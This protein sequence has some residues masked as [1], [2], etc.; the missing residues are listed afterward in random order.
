MKLLTKDTDYA[1]R[2]LLI[3]AQSKGEFVSV[4]EI[5]KKQNMPYHFLRR[6]LRELIKNKIV[7]AKE[8][9]RGGVKIGKDPASVKI[10][11]L[12]KI[13]QGDIRFLECRLRG[14]VC[15]NYSGCTLREKIQKIEDMA[16]K[17]F[18]KITLKALIG[19]SN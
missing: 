2:A 15:R 6:V 10:K 7:I 16:V 14:K 13:F 1:V 12:I 8:G 17:A 3:L 4:R 11:D 19:D 18:S 9:G 5:A